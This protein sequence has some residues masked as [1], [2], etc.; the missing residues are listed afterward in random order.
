MSKHSNAAIRFYSQFAALQSYS[1]D[2]HPAGMPSFSDGSH[3]AFIL[4]APIGSH[5]DGS[6]LAVDGTQQG[7]GKAQKSHASGSEGAYVAI[8]TT[9]PSPQL[10]G[11]GHVLASGWFFV[12]VIR[13]LHL[14]WA[15]L[16][17]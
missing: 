8:E 6:D 3:H 13:D 10:L 16:E 17:W 7:I 5:S 11:Q 12:F 2:S 4:P 1:G 15:E 14:V 9:P